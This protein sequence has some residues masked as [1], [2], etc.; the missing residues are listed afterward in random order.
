MENREQYM[1]EIRKKRARLLAKKRRKIERLEL[2]VKTGLGIAGTGI[3]YLFFGYIGLSIVGA[4]AM[5]K[6][7][8]EIAE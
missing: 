2:L 5:I 1:I 4:Y 7:Y 8:I 6:K 3:F